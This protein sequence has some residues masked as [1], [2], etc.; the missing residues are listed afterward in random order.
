MA[1]LEI[2]RR[3]G[4]GVPKCAQTQH[5]YDRVLVY[6]V[7]KLGTPARSE[8]RRVDA[9]AA[10]LE[11]DSRDSQAYGPAGYVV[12]VLGWIALAAW[13]LVRF[14]LLA[15]LV[16]FEPLVAGVL[17]IAAMLFMGMALFLK[18]GYGATP[19]SFQFAPMFLTGVGCA[20]A[21]LAYYIVI[22]ALLR[23]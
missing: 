12:R 23:R 21:L 16:V 13:D 19:A 20:V 8:R 14:L 15:V 4:N 3:D 1:P 17:S 6:F 2:I 7:S 22:R 11:H 5:G 18:Y 10:L 9:M